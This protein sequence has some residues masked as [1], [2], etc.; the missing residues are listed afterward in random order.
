MGDV[1]T[2]ANVQ[3]SIF[4]G[5]QVKGNYEAHVGFVGLRFKF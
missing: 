3:R 2:G 1:D 4:L 5:D